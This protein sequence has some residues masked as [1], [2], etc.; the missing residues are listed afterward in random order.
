MAAEISGA[1]ADAARLALKIGLTAAD[2]VSFVADLGEEL[3][4][5]KPVLQT[6]K[7]VREKMETVRSN[8]EQL[9]ALHE[10]CTYITA[11][12]IEKCRGDSSELDV[13]PL[14]RHVQEMEQFVLRCQHRRRVARWL[15]ASKVKD[16]IARL[17]ASA[18]SLKSDMG[19]E[20]IAILVGKVN[21]IQ[22]HLVRCSCTCSEALHTI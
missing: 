11:C 17:N 15:K 2:A 19:L 6:L 10:R 20:G 1:A 12:F 4:V 9:I 7:A 16:E 14:E 8:R 22:A 21:E 3:P 13:A 18:D 5:I